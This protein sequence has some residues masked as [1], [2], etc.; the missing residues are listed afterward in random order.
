MEIDEGCEEEPSSS[1]FGYSAAAFVVWPRTTV[2]LRQ[3]AAREQG[4]GPEQA[5]EK[6]GFQIKAVKTS[7]RG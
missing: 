3:N 4:P 7:L 2:V 6:A 1:G 5:A